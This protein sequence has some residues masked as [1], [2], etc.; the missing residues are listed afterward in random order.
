MLDALVK[1]EIGFVDGRH[2]TSQG[3]GNIVLLKKN[4]QKATITDVLYVLSMTSN[5]ISIG[6]LFAKGYNVKMVDNKIEVFYGI[7]RLIL[8]Y[9]KTFKID[10]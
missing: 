9:N 4:G 5:R 7:G 1:K 8:E 10:D 2:V 3:K 6:Q